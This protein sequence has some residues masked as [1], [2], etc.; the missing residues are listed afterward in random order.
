MDNELL[1]ELYMRY[2]R[3]LYFY[4]YALCGIRE[5]AEDICQETFCKALLFLDDGHANCR[6]WLFRVGR[7]IECAVPLSEQT[8][9]IKI[10]GNGPVTKEDSLNYLEQLEDGQRY[11]AYVSLENILEYDEFIILLILSVDFRKYG[12][13][14]VLQKRIRENRS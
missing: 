11:R 3:E 4:L 13:L 2:Y 7:N 9:R 14:H 10:I 1:T 6:A 12:A 5:L 8:D